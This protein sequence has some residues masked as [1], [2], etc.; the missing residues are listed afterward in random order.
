V[1]QVEVS[2]GS[3]QSYAA[4]GVERG[5]VHE[6]IRH[7]EDD[8]RAKLFLHAV[9]VERKGLQIHVWAGS[10]RA[11][12]AS[13]LSHLERLFLADFVEKVSGAAS[14]VYHQRQRARSG[15]ASCM[16]AHEKRQLRTFS[17]VSARS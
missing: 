11:V 1:S 14:S 5:S 7:E 17:T 13:P 2:W 4:V 6:T 12:L 16:L 10:S 8:R 9:S 3:D 15:P